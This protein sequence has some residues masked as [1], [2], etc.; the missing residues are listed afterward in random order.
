MTVRPTI[1]LWAWAAIGAFCG[2]FVLTIAILWP[3]TWRF[4]QSARVLIGSYEAQPQ[5]P[6]LEYAQRELALHLEDDYD[7]NARRL[8]LLFWYLRLAAALLTFE[9]VAWII[10]FTR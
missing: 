2:I 7:R 8:R 9:A 3:Y 10:D 6:S 1:G 5:M 4:N